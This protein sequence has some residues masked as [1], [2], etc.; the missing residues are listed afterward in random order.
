MELA[1]KTVLV[2]GATGLLGG[3]TVGQLLNRGDVRVRIF[4]RDAVKVQK[5]DGCPLEAMLG[6]ITDRDRVREAVAGC[7]VVIHSELP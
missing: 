3:A 6:D 7:D 4:A 5:F 1:G 2:T